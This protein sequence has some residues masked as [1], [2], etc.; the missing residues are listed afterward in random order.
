[1]TERR[2]G[3]VI[4]NQAMADQELPLGISVVDKRSRRPD[5]PLRATTANQ[6]SFGCTLLPPH[7]MSS[8]I[9]LKQ[10]LDPR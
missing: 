5:R 4:V 3:P 7:G 8:S 9:V 10:E 2:K 6:L 1:M